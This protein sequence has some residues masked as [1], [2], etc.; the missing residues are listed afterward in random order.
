MGGWGVGE[1]RVEG[2]LQLVNAVNGLPCCAELVRTR[3]W[4]GEVGG[5]DAGRGPSRDA[6]AGR[7]VQD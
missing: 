6:G 5:S 2:G 1:W 3:L 7:L 4:G